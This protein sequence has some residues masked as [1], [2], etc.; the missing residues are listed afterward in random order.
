MSSCKTFLDA[1]CTIMAWMRSWNVDML[2]HARDS[3][4]IQLAYGVLCVLL[5]VFSVSNES[6]Y[7]AAAER[8]AHSLGIAWGI[9]VL[10]GMHVVAGVMFL[11][12]RV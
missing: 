8:S 9:I 5:G 7:N 11:F 10:A 12:R 6:S 4:E 3:H 1:R 2:R